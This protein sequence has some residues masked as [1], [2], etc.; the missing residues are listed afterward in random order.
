M[1]R[2]FAKRTRWMVDSQSS[3]SINLWDCCCVEMVPNGHHPRLATAEAIH[4]PSHPNQ[5]SPQKIPHF[6]SWVGRESKASLSIPSSCAGSCSLH[7]RQGSEKLPAT[8]EPDGRG[9]PRI[10][11]ACKRR[12]AEHFEG[13]SRWSKAAAGSSSAVQLSGSSAPLEGSVRFS[14]HRSAPVL[15]SYA[16][17][18]SRNTQY[19]QR[20]YSRVIFFYFFYS[21]KCYDLKG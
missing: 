12:L 1:Y 6:P 16:D 4:I 2:P 5:R 14:S 13:R 18:V 15:R 11:G 21:L 8:Q 17:A 10:R 19:C 9:A 7:P 3:I 20:S